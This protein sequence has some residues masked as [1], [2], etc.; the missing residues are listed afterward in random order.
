MA[1]KIKILRIVNRF[2]LGGP[3]YNALFLSRFM[4]DDFETLLIGGAPDIGETDT[5]H[6]FNEYGIKPIIIP[7]LR[8]E[9]RFKHDKKA[10]QKIKRNIEEYQPDIVH[11]HASKAGFLGRY[12]ALKCNVPI[13]LHTFHGH[14]FHSYFG[15]AKTELFKNIERYLA[16]KTS[17]I[18][19]ISPAQ[20]EEL[21]DVYKIAKEEKVHLIPLGFDLQKFTEN[22]AEQRAFTREKYKLKEE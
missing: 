7:E 6:L 12:A 16:Q 15:K 4:S 22:K 18:I 14:V 1:K 5:E 3:V 19:A 20:K 2:N 17:G 10:Y 11:T 21:V 8:R 13:I 9:I